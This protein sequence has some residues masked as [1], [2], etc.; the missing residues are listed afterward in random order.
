M[1]IT[2][3]TENKLL[4]RIEVEAVLETDKATI[5]RVEA[6]KAI[7]KELKIDD[8]LVVVSKITNKFG[9]SKIEVVANVYNTEESLMKNARPHFIKRNRPEVKA[10]GEEA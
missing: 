4:D 10:E 5:K 7:A 8:S 3:K 6:Q 2:K 9:N 1:K